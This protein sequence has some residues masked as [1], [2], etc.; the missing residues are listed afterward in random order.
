MVQDKFEKKTSAKQWKIRERAG[1]R[2]RD[3][4]VGGGGDRE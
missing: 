1:L 3:V 2:G 4:G